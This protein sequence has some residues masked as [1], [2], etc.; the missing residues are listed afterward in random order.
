MPPAD[1]H[2]PLADIGSGGDRHAETHGRILMHI[3]PVGAEQ[4]TPLG[5]AEGR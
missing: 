2:Q 1:R 5:F 4:K 3:P